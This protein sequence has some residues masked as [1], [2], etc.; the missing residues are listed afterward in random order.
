MLMFVYCVSIFDV[1]ALNWDNMDVHLLCSGG[2]QGVC[3]LMYV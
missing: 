1:V 3:V 2:G